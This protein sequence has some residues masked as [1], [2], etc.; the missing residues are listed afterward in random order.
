MGDFCIGWGFT[1]MQSIYRS[2]ENS[3]PSSKSFKK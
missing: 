2:E 3:E 1:N